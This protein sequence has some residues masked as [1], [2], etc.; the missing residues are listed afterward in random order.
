[1]DW[2]HTL[3]YWVKVAHTPLGEGTPHATAWLEQYRPALYAGQLARVRAA[4]RA[5]AG[6]APK[7]VADARHYFAANRTPLRYGK[8]RSRDLQL[9]S[10]TMESGC[11]QLGLARLSI[12]GARWSDPGARLLGKARAAF[13]SHELNLPSWG[14]LHVA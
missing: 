12:A 3:S 10:G 14:A 6:L 4:C 8:F 1:M 11:K 7:A 13:L 5:L 9:G 2:Y